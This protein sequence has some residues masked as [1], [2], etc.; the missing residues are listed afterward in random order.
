MKSEVTAC[1]S[2]SYKTVLDYMYMIS[3]YSRK[4]GVGG[5]RDEGGWGKRQTTHTP[6]AGYV[7]KR[8]KGLLSR[9]SEYSCCLGERNGV[10]GPW[11]M[12]PA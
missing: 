8:T 3:H 4:E 5:V 10:G 7:E 2:Q 6:R 12:T 9:N 1:S 11:R